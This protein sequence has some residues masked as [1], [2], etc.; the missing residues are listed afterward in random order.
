MEFVLTVSITMN[1]SFFRPAFSEFEDVVYIRW[2]SDPEGRYCLS[3][4]R[5]ES[6]PVSAHDPLD[7]W[8][9]WN[10]T[11]SG[12]IKKKGLCKIRLDTKVRKLE[13]ENAYFLAIFWCLVLK[14]SKNIKFKNA[15]WK[16]TCQCSQSIGR[17]RF[18][19]LSVY[20]FCN[21]QTLIVSWNVD[22]TQWLLTI[23]QKIWCES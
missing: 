20:V 19:G 10:G 9:R 13:L 23:F 21:F 3:A 5:S 8:G 11:V 4:M 17:L 6:Q 2:R 16:P 7:V 15:K 18:Q 14:D 12:S 1:L 22:W